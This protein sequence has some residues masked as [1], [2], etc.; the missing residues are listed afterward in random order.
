MF[1]NDKMECWYN[2]E[3]KNVLKTFKKKTERFEHNLMH[4]GI[5][6]MWCGFLVCEAI[7]AL[8][9]GRKGVKKSTV[10]VMWV[11]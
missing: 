5:Q 11:I 4:A 10:N 8:Q 2:Q 1:E 7:C 9:K 3:N 6:K